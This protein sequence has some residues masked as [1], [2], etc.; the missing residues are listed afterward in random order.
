M[1]LMTKVANRDRRS[2]RLWAKPSRAERIGRAE[3]EHED[4]HRDR[5]HA[6]DERLETILRQSTNVHPGRLRLAPPRSPHGAG[7]YNN[8]VRDGLRADLKP[9]TRRVR[10]CGAPL[11]G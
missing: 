4:R 1:K 6:V 11:S 10:P 7:L 2:N 8:R 3:L 5:E 9:Q